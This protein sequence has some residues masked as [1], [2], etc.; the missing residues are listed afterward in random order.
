MLTKGLY[1]SLD[2]RSGS[3]QN[4]A[5]FEVDKSGLWAKILL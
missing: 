2:E 4:R 5:V 1:R 3:G